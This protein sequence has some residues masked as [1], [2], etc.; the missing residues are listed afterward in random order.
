MPEVAGKLQTCG[1]KLTEWSKNS[2][3]SIRKVLKEKRKLLSRAE[4]DAVRGVIKCW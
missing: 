4:L 2:F 3:G 1:E